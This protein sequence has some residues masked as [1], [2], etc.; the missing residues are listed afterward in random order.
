[1]IS[2]LSSSQAF[3][4]SMGTVTAML[5]L[6]MI[7]MWRNSREPGLLLAGVAYL[8]TAAQNF[9]VASFGPHPEGAVW[10]FHQV[11]GILAM[12]LLM[13]G[14]MTYV[15]GN[16]RHLVRDIATQLAVFFPVLALSLY[17]L[18]KALAGHA[19]FS[20][21]IMLAAWHTARAIPR[22]PRI[23]HG[24]VLASLLFQPAVLMLAFF[25][26]LHEKADVRTIAAVPWVFIGMTLLGVSL[27]RSRARVASELAHRTLAEGQVRKLM[28]VDTI[29]GLPSRFAALEQIETLI[30][31]QSP[32]GLLILN[33]DAFRRI[34]DHF[35]LAGGDAF[36]CAV[37]QRILDFRSTPGCRVL[38]RSGVDEFMLVI[39]A[40]DEQELLNL[41]R[42]LNNTFH[43]AIRFDD[44]E[45][46]ASVSMGLAL[47]PDDGC[48][49]EMLLRNA[50]TALHDSQQ[51]GGKGYQRYQSNMQA[52]LQE[53]MWLD[54]QLHL[55]LKHGDFTLHYQPKIDLQ[56]GSKANAKS[57]EALI[58]WPHTERGNIS[59][60]QFIP[61]A[62]TNGVI[63]P[64]GRWVL[65]EA[66][67]QARR[68]L[69]QGLSMRIAVNLSARQFS[70]AA[71]LD[72]LAS[73]QRV[74]GGLLDLEVTESSVMEQELHA[75]NILTSCRELG[76]GIHMDDFGTGYSS[77]AQLVRLPLTAVKLDRSFI[78]GSATERNQ[79]LVR[80][81]VAAVTELGLD[82]VAEGVETQQQAEFLR[83]I[84]V[85]YAQGWLYTPAVA[86]DAIFERYGPSTKPNHIRLIN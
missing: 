82:V 24:W 38:A 45:V 65:A 17:L 31:Q 59:P 66:A 67:R 58:R 2:T 72:H 64:L 10:W 3:A 41:A 32:F 29:T 19:A 12:T 54:H 51:A 25:T 47:H 4:L 42:A 46:F 39:H 5:A 52:L 61:R 36:I 77:L 37:A 20:V 9:E 18:P 62:E 57:V 35:G 84:G 13:A 27:N 53:Q 76:Y 68:W 74:A 81:M 8:C 11:N 14:I 49:A 26:G 7:G 71:I 1:M 33:I 80:S 69:E 79:A 75:I 86:A 16:T 73:A 6:L 43:Q 55:A 23:G 40:I 70:D 60:A 56:S 85:H 63:V 22:E 28:Y 50:A 21:L 83:H 34:N 44:N 78:C 15:R 48:S 30:Q